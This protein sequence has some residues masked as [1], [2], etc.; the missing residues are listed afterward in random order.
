MDL[1]GVTKECLFN[2]LKL[3]PHS[4]FLLLEGDVPLGCYLEFR[5]FGLGFFARNC[6]T[7]V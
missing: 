6:F 3:V 4:I 1:R 5:Y 7:V 2:D